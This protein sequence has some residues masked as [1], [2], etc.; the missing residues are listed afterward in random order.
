[1]HA[2]AAKV[3]G[4]FLV[5]ISDVIAADGGL[6]ER[7]DGC[8]VALGQDEAVAAL[9]VRILDVIVH[10]ILP[11]GGHHIADRQVAAD[12]DE[13]LMRQIQKP[14]LRRQGSLLHAMD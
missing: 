12:M 6:T 2:E 13:R 11:D 3:G 1:M 10:C 8:R 7:G 4:V 5:D 14:D 9:P